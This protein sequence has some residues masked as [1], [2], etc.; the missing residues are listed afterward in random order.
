MKI[1]LHIGMPKTGSTTI[2]RTLLLNK[3][4]LAKAG[5]YYPYRT[6]A[7]YGLVTGTDPG[8]ALAIPKKYHTLIISDE[9]LFN[10]VRSPEQ[11]AAIAN[12]LREISS[13]INFIS[14]VRREDEVFV[15]AYFTRLLMGSAVK[16]EDLPL[17]PVQTYTRLSSWNEPFGLENMIVRRFGQSYL[18]DGLVAD[19][20]KTVGIDHLDLE[21][22]PNANSSPRS[23]VLEIIRLLNAT[24]GDRELDRHVLK[25]VARAVG[26]GDPVGLSAQDRQTLI[27][28]AQEQNRMLSDCYFGGEQVFDH[29]VIDNEPRR[30]EIGVEQLRAVA[31]RMAEVHGIDLAPAPATFDEAL[32]WIRGVADACLHSPQARARRRSA[33]ALQKR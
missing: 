6:N 10:R 4:R 22:E 9:R 29:P 27:E 14:Y 33:K 23:D 1:F 7:L 24:R 20:A 13:D 32:E 16:L 21:K 19:F 31:E 17:S 25:A 28:R 8:P 11:A 30:P 15:S 26:F 12:A 5:V 3:S 2:Q 18:P